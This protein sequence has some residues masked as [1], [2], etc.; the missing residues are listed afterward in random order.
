MFLRGT[1]RTVDLVKE[2][3]SQHADDG[4]DQHRT[5]DASAPGVEPLLFTADRAADHGDAR[6]QEHAGDER[7]DDRAFDQFA[8]RLS[9]RD[10]VKDDLDNGAETGVDDGTHA[11]R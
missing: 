8:F 7:A 2:R 1:Y 6:H 5:R 9:E 4:H 3:W 10:G 11:D